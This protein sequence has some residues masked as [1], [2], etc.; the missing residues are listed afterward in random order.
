M[1][2][3]QSLSLLVPEMSIDERADKRVLPEWAGF[4]DLREPLFGK[5]GAEPCLCGLP[6]HDMVSWAWNAQ[7][8][9]YRWVA[10]CDFIEEHL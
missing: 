7:C 5:P 3:D 10:I 4:R 8:G 1:H 9:I 2:R 6:M